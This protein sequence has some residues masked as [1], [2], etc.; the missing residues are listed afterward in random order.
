MSLLEEVYEPLLAD[1]RRRITNDRVLEQL[2]SRSTDSKTL[3]RFLI[4][5]SALS[6]QIT[7]PVDG[8]LRRAS[9]K[10]FEVGEDATGTEFD[11]HAHHEEGH[12]LMLIEDTAKLV[13]RW[14]ELY[15]DEKLD[16]KALT[17]QSPTKAMQAY[18]D[19]HEDVI[20][21]RQPYAQAAIALEIESLALSWAPKF[22]ENVEAVLGKEIYAD[23]SFLHEHIALDVGHTAFN[24]RLMN[25]LLAARGEEVEAIADAG[26]SSLHAYLDFVTEVWTRVQGALAGPGR[27]QAAT[28]TN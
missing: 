21:S 17:A 26:R 6:V 4:E 28:G 22:V 9:K 25:D 10:C 24:K 7:E 5:Y 20:A 16:P 14:N 27:T 2:N 18:I 19:L 11:K 23:L 15:P 13:A 1:A 3:L 12:H 8:W